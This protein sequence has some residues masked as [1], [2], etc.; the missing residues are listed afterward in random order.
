MHS[1]ATARAQAE[2][3]YYIALEAIAAGEPQQ[4]IEACRRALALDP[5]LLDAMHALIRAHQ[6]AGEYD[7][8][9][10]AAQ[11]LALLD[12]EDVLAYTSLSILYQHKGLVPEAEAA[13][14]KAKLLGWKQ[15]LRAG[16]PA[17]DSG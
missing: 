8:G 3:L 12:P 6:D 5:S 10:A 17:G 11:E 1:E 2:A 9:I 13:A 14:L 15:Q 7:R 16:R 4:A